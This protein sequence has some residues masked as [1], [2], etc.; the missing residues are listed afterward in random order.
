MPKTVSNP[1]DLTYRFQN[2][3]IGP[4]F[5]GVGREGADPS[6]VEFDGRYYLF[7]SMSAGFWHSDDLVEWTHAEMPG[8]P[9]YDYAPDARV[10]DGYLVV[11]AS[12][13]RKPCN[14][15]RSKSPL[16]GEWEEIPGTF[17]FWDPNLFQDDDGR[18]YLYQGCSSRKP[19]DVVELDRATFRPIGTP[20]ALIAS[21]VDHHGWERIGDNWDPST[22]SSNP[23]FKAI[24]GAAPYIEGAWLTKHNGIYY[25]QYSAPGTELN[26]YADGYYTSTSPLGPFTYS[27]HSPFSSKPGGFMPG[28]GHGSTMQDR[29]GNWWHVA[30]MRI[31][32]NY[33]FERR[34]GLFPAGFDANGVLFCNQEFSDYPMTIPDGPA[35]PWSLSAQSMLLSHGTVA[36]AS[37]SAEGHGPELVTNEDAQTWWVAGDSNAGHWV[38]TELPVGSTVAGVQVNLAEHK[39]RPPKPSRSET[40]VVVPFRRHLYETTPPAEF[41]LQASVDGV[42]WVDLVDTRGSSE[43]RSNLYLE[44]DRPAVYRFVRVTGFTQPF[45]AVFAVSGLRVFGRGRGASPVVVVPTAKRTSDLNALI[46]WDKVPGASG[47]NVRYGITADTLY[48]SWLVYDQDSLDLGAL[49]AGQDYWVAVDSFNDNGVTRGTAVPVID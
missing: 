5:R 42:D 2:V 22:A 45:G 33:S 31:S 7:V 23:I 37:S 39:V 21:D 29:H 40:T 16:D 47:Y 27:A 11:C 49:N 9:I 10:I 12:R 32:K 1:I 4:F 19:I 43:S 18:V 35:D 30:T 46:S 38:Q 17:A 13:A 15:Y 3:S 25:L 36:T 44:L 48:S 20:V 6:M 28:A 41:L 14:F 8:L 24:T 34:I 26:T